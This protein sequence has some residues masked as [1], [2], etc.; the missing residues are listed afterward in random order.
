MSPRSKAVKWGIYNS[1]TRGVTCSMSPRS[2]AVS[3][4]VSSMAGTMYSNAGCPMTAT[5]ATTATTTTTSATTAATTIMGKQRSC[6]NR[7]DSGWV[8][9]DKSDRDLVDRK[10]SCHIITSHIILY[11]VMSCNIII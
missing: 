9:Y 2:K 1:V 11:H 4:V 6:V 5:T 8:I 3:F 7:V 10:D